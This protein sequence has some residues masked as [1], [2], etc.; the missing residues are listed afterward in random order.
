M[1]DPIDLDPRRALLEARDAEAERG[2]GEARVARQHEAGKLT[3]RERLARFLDAGTFVELDRL[4]TH[5]CTELGMAAQ[6]IPGDGVVTGHGLVEGRPVFVYAQDFTVFGGSLSGAHAEKI[7][8]VLDL[9]LEVGCPVVGL[10]DSGGARVQEGVAS[11]AGYADIFLRHTLASG[12]VPQV[13]VVM[14]PC[15]GAAAFAPAIADFTFMVERTSSLFVAGPDAI[16]DAAGVEVTREALGGA[17]VHAERSGVAQFAF[18]T[19]EE[20]LAAVRELLAYLPSR[21]GAPLPARPCTDDPTRR[22]AALRTLVPEA[23]DAAYDVRAVIRAVVDDRRLFEVAAERAPNVVVGFARVEGWPVGVV[24]NQPAALG[25]LLDGG[26]AVKAARFVRCCDAFGLPL[27]T[28]VDVP[29]FRPGTDEEGGGLAL[30]GAKLLYAYAEATVPK[31]TVITRHAYGGAYA[32]MASKHLRAD[33]NLAFPSAEI[34]VTSPEAAVNV[35]HRKE[36]LAAGD[37]AAQDAA[38]RRL[39]AAYRAEYAT[40]YKAAELGYVDEVIRPEDTRPRVSRALAMLRT[41]RQ[42][43]PPKKH[44]NIPL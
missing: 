23:R 21:A 27:L 16:R 15:A 25:G 28:F 24:A 4:K 32:V 22:D 1:P 41:K 20:T 7:C 13:S 14:G 34:A 9:A 26:A 19:E 35:V 40:P 11:L 42:E 31:V 5:R 18:D 29:G 43:L 44:G 12:V 33:V 38:R 37:A 30:Q 2:G 10:A 17:R 39:V 6:K 3:A 8:K 36:I